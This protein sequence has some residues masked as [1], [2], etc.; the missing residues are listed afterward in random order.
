MKVLTSFIFYLKVLHEPQKNT[1]E[2]CMQLIKTLKKYLK[3]N[4]I[5]T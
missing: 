4:N 2:F 3:V 5:I 1:F